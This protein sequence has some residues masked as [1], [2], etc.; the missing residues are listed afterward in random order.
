MCDISMVLSVVRGH[1]FH[2]RLRCS[3][4]FAI[5]DYRS[6]S[7]TF[8]L[9]WSHGWYPNI[10]LVHSLR[11]LFIYSGCNLCNG[12]RRKSCRRHAVVIAL[13][14]AVA[15]VAAWPS[16]L[17]SEASALWNVEIINHDLIATDDSPLMG[18]CRYFLLLVRCSASLQNTSKVGRRL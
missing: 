8:E 15:G 2:D 3:T 9:F 10:V 7:V 6:L 16:I 18:G 13:E 11:T 17:S 14:G 1:T 12:V 5:T 4:S